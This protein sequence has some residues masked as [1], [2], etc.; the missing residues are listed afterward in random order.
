MRSGRAPSQAYAPRWWVGVE[1]RFCGSQGLFKFFQIA[2]CPC[3]YLG[4]PRRSGAHLDPPSAACSEPPLRFLALLDA[5][6]QSSKKGRPAG[7][8]GPGPARSA[9]RICTGFPR[10]PVAR[11][12]TGSPRRPAGA[13]ANTGGPHGGP[14]GFS[15]TS[16]SLFGASVARLEPPLNPARGARAQGPVCRPLLQTQGGLPPTKRVRAQTKSLSMNDAME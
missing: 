3:G 12:N 15:T 1:G 4:F 13:R 7:P 11:A 16:R 5:P 14:P 8:R 6:S 9:S 2:Q 10:R